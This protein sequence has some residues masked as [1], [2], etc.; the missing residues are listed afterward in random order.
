LVD[1]GFHPW[2]NQMWAYENPCAPTYYSQIATSPNAPDAMQAPKGNIY[3]VTPSN[4]SILW[5]T[6]DANLSS[7]AQ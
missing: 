5:H 3:G 4:A 2:G 7:F 6:Q 1:Y